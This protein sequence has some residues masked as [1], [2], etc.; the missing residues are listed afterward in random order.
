M[1]GPGTQAKADQEAAERAA[2]LAT[3]EAEIAALDAKKQRALDIAKKNKVRE[4][5]WLSLT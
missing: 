5:Q 1:V 3:V 2:L 4:L